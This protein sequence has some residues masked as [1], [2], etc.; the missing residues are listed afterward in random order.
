MSCHTADP[1]ATSTT[2]KETPRKISFHMTEARHTGQSLRDSA[3]TRGPRT[4]E[5]LGIEALEE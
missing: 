4:D 2:P 3:F 5:F 1:K